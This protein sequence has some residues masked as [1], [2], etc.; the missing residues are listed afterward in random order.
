MQKEY[1]DYNSTNTFFNVFNMW[2]TTAFLEYAIIPCK[3]HGEW[4]VH[5]S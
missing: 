5:L 2:L 4:L 3:M 1:I